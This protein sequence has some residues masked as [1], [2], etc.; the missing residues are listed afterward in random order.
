M[1]IWLW[2]VPL[3]IYYKIK[4]I[5]CQKMVAFVLI[6]VCVLYFLHQL[7]TN[8]VTQ[9]IH[10]IDTFYRTAPRKFR[11]SFSVCIQDCSFKTLFLCSCLLWY[12]YNHV[13]CTSIIRNAMRSRQ[14]AELLVSEGDS[15]ALFHLMQLLHTPPAL[16][17]TNSNINDILSTKTDA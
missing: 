2:H 13:K 14:L 16:I 9:F 3:R 17:T 15:A 4:C 11:K 7:C 5:L 6:N 8:T 1:Y 10:T 12:L